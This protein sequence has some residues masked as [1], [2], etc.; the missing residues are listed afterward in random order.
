M[1][2][3]RLATHVKGH[4]ARTIAAAPEAG[5]VLLESRVLAETQS[6]AWHRKHYE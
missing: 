4:L 5:S 3:A 1:A 2:I 6:S